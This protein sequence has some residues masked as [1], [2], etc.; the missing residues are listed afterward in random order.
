MTTTQGR[1]GDEGSVLP[2]TAIV[3]A[4]AVV[5]AMALVAIVDGSVSRARAQ[6]A[7]DAGA[8]AAVAV[9]GDDDL[10]RLTGLQ[11]VERN[12]AE[13][14]EYRQAW[15]DQPSPSDGSGEGELM[16]RPLR[17]TI[18]ADYSGVKAVATAERSVGTIGTK[19]DSPD[20]PV[21]AAPA[22]GWA[23][24]TSGY[25]DLELEAG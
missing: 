18:V 9:A 8:L 2:L 11:L 5:A 22:L 17:V 23:M 19:I 20:G 7:A 24:H 21:S 13:L 16:V 15:V 6:V 10:G 3:V 12:G 4:L 14:V 25:A 1:H